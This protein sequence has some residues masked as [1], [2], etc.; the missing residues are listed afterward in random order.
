MSAAT[1]G[2]RR[3]RR[4]AELDARRDSRRARQAPPRRAP[5][6]SPMVLF[7]L[8]A[9]VIGAV[10]LAVAFFSRP[11]AETASH[12]ITSPAQ[13]VPAGLADGRTLGKADAKVTIEIWSDFQCPACRTLAVEVEPSIISAYVVSGTARL[14]YRDAAFQ[15]VRG[16]PNYD[17]SVYAGAAARCAADQG[18]F[19]QMHDWLFANWAGENKGAFH[20]E[21]LSS[22]AS[23]AGLNA[24][25]YNSCMAAGTMQSA[26]KAETA[27][28]VA[29][30]VNSTPTLYI[31]G[32]RFTGTP[33]I[34]QLSQ[35]IEAAAQ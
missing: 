15:G 25:T 21:R 7:T 1:T 17:E 30:G 26:V 35:M 31:N 2:S 10:V 9:L 12:E 34:A 32:Q 28:G 6:Q 27:Q 16:D 14:V 5:W 23:H 20:A 13:V 4:Q 33:S 18:R 11:P 3:A 19:W 8:A 29:A 22:I 24:E